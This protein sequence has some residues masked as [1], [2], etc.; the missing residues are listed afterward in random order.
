MIFFMSLE[1]NFEWVSKVSILS[2]WLGFEGDDAGNFRDL[3]LMDVYGE[4]GDV[5]ILCSCATSEYGVSFMGRFCNMMH[6]Q[7]TTGN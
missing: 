6:L 2:G 3:S 5:N 7:D 4:L 1:R